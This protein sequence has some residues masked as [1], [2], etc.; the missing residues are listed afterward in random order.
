MKIKQ[1]FTSSVRIF[2]DGKEQ[3]LDEKEWSLEDMGAMQIDPVW[4]YYKKDIWVSNIGYV[5]QINVVNAQRRFPEDA[6]ERCN[7]FI[8]KYKETGAVFGNLFYEERLLIKVCTFIPKDSGALNKYG[9]KAYGAELYVEQVKEPLHIM[10]AKVFLGKKEG[11]GKVVHHID[12]NS[13]NNS[14]SN[15]IC[16]NPDIHHVKSSSGRNI[17]HPYSPFKTDR[18][19]NYEKTLKS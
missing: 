14:V 7:E 11:D 19:L 4:M 12:N 6:A 5:A 10:I 13:F 18:Q 15:L 17:L 8:K 1:I 16:V 9:D 2:K 3:I